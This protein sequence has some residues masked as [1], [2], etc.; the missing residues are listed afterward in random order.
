MAAHRTPN[1]TIDL[2]ALTQPAAGP[3]RRACTRPDELGVPATEAAASGA[4]TSTAEPAP[5]P[6]AARRRKAARKPVR[7]IAGGHK[8]GK[9]FDVFVPAS[10]HGDEPGGSIDTH[11]DFDEGQD[12]AA[13]TTAERTAVEECVSSFERVTNDAEALGAFDFDATDEPRI[14]DLMTRFCDHEYKFQM[15]ILVLQTRC[16]TDADMV[17]ADGRKEALDLAHTMMHAAFRG[18]YTAS[19]RRDPTQ[20]GA[21]PSDVTRKTTLLSELKE[22]IVRAGWMLRRSRTAGAVTLEFVKPKYYVDPATGMRSLCDAT[23][24]LEGGAGALDVATEVWRLFPTLHTFTERGYDARRLATQLSNAWPAREAVRRRDMWAFGD[25]GAGVCGGVYMANSHEFK[26]WSEIDLERE[27]VL[28]LMF[29]E[30]GM[31][32]ALLELPDPTSPEA[33]R[34]LQSDGG[35]PAPILALIHKYLPHFYTVH[36]WQGH[37]K[38]ANDGDRYAPLVVAMWAYGKLFLMRNTN[39]ALARLADGL[40]LRPCDPRAKRWQFDCSQVALWLHGLPEVGKTAILEAL[41][42][43]LPSAAVVSL[44][45]EGESTFCFDE[46]FAEVVHFVAGGEMRGKT[47]L[48]ATFLLKAIGGEGDRLP[49]KHQQ[50]LHVDAKDAHLAFIFAG[51]QYTDQSGRAA[52]GA[53]GRRVP[54]LG[55]TTPV[56][57]DSIDHELF[58]HNNADP[59]RPALIMLASFVWQTINFHET[60]GNFWSWAGSHFEEGRAQFMLSVCTLQQILEETDWWDYDDPDAEM[61]YAQFKAQCRKYAKELETRVSF[62]DVAVVKDALRCKGLTLDRRREGGRTTEWVKG[63]ALPTTPLPAD[64]GLA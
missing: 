13:M 44:S 15:A 34:M 52:A 16:V 27:G 59:H 31:P 22:C 48:P 54:Y 26:P 36:A 6:A 28:P 11:I 14:V 42:R 41:K 51:N 2:S 49:V 55:F 57:K 47:T 43:C 53:A 7:F 5:E 21:R 64:S 9:P 38:L 20:P 40:P 12:T 39:R 4:R 37:H 46:L 60:K 17:W 35:K 63:V 62:G 23:P 1:T 58:S 24:V 25:K 56:D 50:T 30:H 8:A 10:E 32:E 33:L 61:P 19:V 45:N 18:L 3:L 29:L